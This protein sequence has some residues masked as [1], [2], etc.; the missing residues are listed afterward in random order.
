MA[1]QQTARAHALGQG[2]SDVVLGEL[3]DR[4]RA[5]VAGVDGGERRRVRKPRKQEVVCPL[6][7]AGAEADQMKHPLCKRYLTM[8]RVMRAL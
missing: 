2:G 8:G 3:L 7:R 1:D 6:P 5:N 4:E